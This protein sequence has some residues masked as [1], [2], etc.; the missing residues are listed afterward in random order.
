MAGGLH[1]PQTRR[2][3]CFECSRPPDQRAS[4]IPKGKTHSL[5]S[6]PGF[7]IRTMT[8]RDDCWTIGKGEKENLSFDPK[9]NGPYRLQA[10]SHMRLLALTIPLLNCTRIW[11]GQSRSS[12][13]LEG[14]ME[15]SLLSFIPAPLCPVPLPLGWTGTQPG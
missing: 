2:P 13:H 15:L 4:S 12:P 1:P 14:G 8:S 6:D 10:D 7:L 9:E 3:G 11:G 5:V